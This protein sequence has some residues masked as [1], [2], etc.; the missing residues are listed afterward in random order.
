M[1]FRKAAIFRNFGI[2]ILFVLGIVA[3]ER[4]LEDIAVDLA[5]QRPFDVGDTIIE[6]VAY[7]ISRDSSRVDN[8]DPNKIPLYLLGVNR[9]NDFGLLRGD[10]VTQLSLPFNGANFGENPV[11]DQVVV[12]IPYFS[13]REGDQNAVDPDTGLP[14]DSSHPNWENRVTDYKY[15]LSQGLSIPDQYLMDYTLW[16]LGLGFTTG[17][18]HYTP[19]GWLGVRSGISTSFMAFSLSSTTLSGGV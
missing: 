19:L 7:N 17:Y 5:G 13:T 9:D 4:D 12:T 10:L 3:C 8:N 11:I 15:A 2:V 14:I 1:L 6:V 16:K 18:R